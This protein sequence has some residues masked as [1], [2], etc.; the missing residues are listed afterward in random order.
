M[1]GK[2]GKIADGKNNENTAILAKS[3]DPIIFGR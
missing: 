1:A 3:P 2:S